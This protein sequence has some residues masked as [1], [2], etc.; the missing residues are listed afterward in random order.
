MVVQKRALTSSSKSKPGINHTHLFVLQSTVDNDREVLAKK[1]L[2]IY[3]S[4]H[5]CVFFL[6]GHCVEGVRDSI[7]VEY[8]RVI[9]SVRQEKTSAS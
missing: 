9:R 3:A 6:T 1:I 4:L 5:I 8:M 7:G 2:T